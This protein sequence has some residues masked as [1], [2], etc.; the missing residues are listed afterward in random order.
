MATNPYVFETANVLLGI[1]SHELDL[2][3]NRCMIYNQRRIIGNTDDMHLVISFLAAFP[4]GNVV[5]YAKN[6][7][8]Q[9]EMEEQVVCMQ[10][11]YQVDVM[12][13]N[14]EAARRK[15]EVLMALASTYSIQ[16]QETHGFHIAPITGQFNDV[17]QLEGTARLNRY[18]LH[19][20]VLR[21]YTKTKPVDYY[22]VFHTPQISSN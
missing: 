1:I 9:Q 10:E 2:P 11:S 20:T 6:E 16:A 3:E 18:A 21:A 12:S 22:S 5:R 13:R 14:M 4:Y 7:T 17:S 15:H 19:V 8:T